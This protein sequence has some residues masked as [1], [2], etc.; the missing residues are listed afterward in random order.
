[1][2]GTIRIGELARRTGV[3]PELL[4]AWE[5]RY[6]LLQPSRSDGGFRLYSAMDE[7]RIRRMTTLIAEGLSAAEA[8]RHALNGGGGPS[9]NDTPIVDQ[10][11]DRL[12]AA[13][14]EFDAA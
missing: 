1:M 13:L 5:H 12:R 4:R 7:A 6:G 14:D 10:L 9:A 3:S 2:D 11:A 8:A